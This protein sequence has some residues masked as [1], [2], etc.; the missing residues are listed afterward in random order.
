LRLG[1][2]DTRLEQKIQA[3]C[4]RK[5]AYEYSKRLRLI[6]KRGSPTRVPPG[7]VMRP[8]VTFVNCVYTIKILEYC[9]QLSISLTVIFPRSAC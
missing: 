8:A 3:C 9:R 6:L 1:L 7:Y 2:K 5:Q 4:K